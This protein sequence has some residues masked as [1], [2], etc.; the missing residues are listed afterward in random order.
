MLD[1]NYR[2][3]VYYRIAFQLRKKRLCRIFGKLILVRIA[4]VPGVEINSV[5]PLGRGFSLQHAHDIVIGYGAVIKENVTL[6][7]G[8]TL[9]AKYEINKNNNNSDNK[10]NNYPT[11]HE[12]VIIFPGAKV[13]GNIEIGANSI[14]GA[15]S[16]VLDSFPEN[17]LIAGNPAKKIKDII[18]DEI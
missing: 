17:S 9:G 4:R 11:I 15:N 7:N 3:L 10:K 14:I 12:N 1:F 13:I 8:V 18:P 6:Y 16:V 5:H 2:V